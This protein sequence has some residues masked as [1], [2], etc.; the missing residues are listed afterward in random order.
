LGGTFIRWSMISDML[1]FYL[2]LVP[3]ALVLRERHRARAGLQVDVYT[4]GGLGY[5]FFGALGAAV[6]A[7]VL[8]AQL[9]AYVS[10]AGRDAQ[11]PQALFLAFSGAI[12]DGVWGTLN[13]IL[14][15]T[16]WLGM[17]LVLRRE[18]RVLGWVT[19]VLGVFMLLRDV[20]VGSL[21]MVGL[22]VYFVLAPI[23]GA[24]IGVDLL[25]REAGVRENQ[26]RKGHG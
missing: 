13:P 3:L 19:I 25:R 12:Y 17:G 18:H 24:W 23:W 2:L 14:G 6:L 9:D 5:L 21:E 1:G 10:A 8:P 26:R 4:L 15:G 16:W 20:K 22:A 11:V 7:A